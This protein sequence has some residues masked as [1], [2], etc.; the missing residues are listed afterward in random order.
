MNE[1]QASKQSDDGR[2]VESGVSYD[3][4]KF[5]YPA[6]L[7]EGTNYGGNK[8]VFFINVQGASKIATSEG[9]KTVKLEPYRYLKSSGQ[10][11]K[12]ALDAKS[13]R[14]AKPAK[15]LTTAISLYIPESLVKNYSVNWEMDDG[16]SSQLGQL[17]T[18][19][20]LAGVAGFSNA[21]NE[22]R[23]AEGAI[24]AGKVAGASAGS[25]MLGGSAFAQKSFG[26][27]PGNAKAQ[28]LFNGVDFGGF[29]FDYKFAPK[30]SQEAA[31]VLS[32]IRTFRHHMLPEFLDPKSKYIYIYPSEFEIRYYIG[33]TENPF[34]ER[35]ITAV[36]TSM[37]VNYTPNGQYT[38]FP[39]GMPTHINLTL[40]FKDLGTPHKEISPDDKAGA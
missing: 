15:R 1:R 8:V 33:S 6:D 36:L 20:I 30:N 4:S 23:I 32:I 14:I 38:T 10:E 29:T 17:A 3:I 25:L 5:Q 39:D 35:H 7:S 40:Q 24:E 22:T 16:E 28:L 37:N 12:T 11:A 9:S 26:L 18:K 13:L 34:L 19:A 31:N 21:S 27:T 2:F